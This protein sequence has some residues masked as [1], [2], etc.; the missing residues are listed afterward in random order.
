ML[1]RKI[2]SASVAVVLAAGTF[3]TTAFAQTYQHKGESYSYSIKSNDMVT[4]VS[5]GQYNATTSAG[6]SSGGNSRYLEVAVFEKDVD[7]GKTLDYADD[8][9]TS[10]NAG[11]G[12]T[13]SRDYDSKGV[14]YVHQSLIKPSADNSYTISST[15]TIIRQD[16]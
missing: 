4:S 3:V 10:K 7:T 9:I 14:F 13:I 11:T 16:Y 6:I 5:G 8:S 12:C 2:V 1:I 15:N